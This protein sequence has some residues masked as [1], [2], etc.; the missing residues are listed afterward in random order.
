MS[1]RS[2][3]FTVIVEKDDEGLYVASVLELEG[4]HTQ[5]KSI[6]MLMIRVAEAIELCAG[7]MPL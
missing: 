6:E 1:A 7:E 2:T 4:C 3:L 5:A